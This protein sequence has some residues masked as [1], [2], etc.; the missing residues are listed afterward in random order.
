MPTANELIEN[1]N[2]LFHSKYEMN[3]PQSIISVHLNINQDDCIFF[4]NLSNRRKSAPAPPKF[5]E[6]LQN[7]YNL[8]NTLFEYQLADRITLVR[9][10]E[11][12][13]DE[14]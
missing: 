12:D 7:L 1:T 3:L 11:E 2:K 6:L 10:S 13:S 4:V 14:I 8:C 5:C 9:F